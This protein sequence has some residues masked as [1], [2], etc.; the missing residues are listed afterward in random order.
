M[1]EEALVLADQSEERYWEAEVHRLKGELLLA[2]SAENQ[3]EV[4]ACFHKALDVARRQEAKSWSCG[5]P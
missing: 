3:M 2:R 5:Q 4:E 1:L